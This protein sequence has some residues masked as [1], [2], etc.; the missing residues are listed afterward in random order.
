MLADASH[1]IDKGSPALHSQ[2]T[3][4]PHRFL[5]SP[6]CDICLS[7]QQGPASPLTRLANVPDRVTVGLQSTRGAS[8][9]LEEDPVA[10]SGTVSRRAL[11]ASAIQPVGPSPNVPA[12]VTSG[13]ALRPQDVVRRPCAPPAPFR[14]ASIC[15]DIVDSKLAQYL[16][17]SFRDPSRWKDH[18]QPR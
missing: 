16:W 5:S 11:L 18:V 4:L 12:S 7:V 17:R 6:F 1:A 9:R 14:L 2:R 10:A 13:R 3:P 15:P 8:P